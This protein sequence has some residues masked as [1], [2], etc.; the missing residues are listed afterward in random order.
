MNEEMDGLSK[1][2]LASLTPQEREERDRDLQALHGALHDGTAPAAAAPTDSGPSAPSNS[3]AEQRPPET[4]PGPSPSPASSE[5]EKPQATE[6]KEEKALGVDYEQRYKS[7]EGR[8]RAAGGEL[9]FE[10]ERREELE[11]RLVEVQ[12]QLNAAKAAR[13]G[14]PGPET[15]KAPDTRGAEQEGAADFVV[16]LDKLPLSDEARLMLQDQPEIGALLRTAIEAS[17]GQV[18]RSVRAQMEEL[19]RAHSESQLALQKRAEMEFLTDLEALRPGFSELDKT[20]EWSKFLDGRVLGIPRRE[21]LRLAKGARDAGPI[22]DCVDAFTA[23]RGSGNG[24]SPAN[25]GATVSPGNVARPALSSPPMEKKPQ[26]Y[27]YNQYQMLLSDAEQRVLTART[28]EQLR[29][30]EA[31][32]DELEAALSDGRVTL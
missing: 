4:T 14:T 11:R 9:R 6:A 2:E 23:S 27:T 5:P 1:E 3:A 24:A 15:P 13:E 30:A 19:R 21:A 22:L 25:T 8:I 17:V 16:D 26:T 12:E 32:S 28:D 31:D 18:A 10:R 29:Q 20:P 7:A